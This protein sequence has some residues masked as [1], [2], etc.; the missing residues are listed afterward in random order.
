MIFDGFKIAAAPFITDAYCK[1]GARLHQVSN[2]L[3]G[4]ALFCKECENV[5]QLKLIKTPAKKVS[6]EFLKQA[7]KETKK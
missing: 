6:D 2:G 1:C 5:Y 4:A 3:L 7:H